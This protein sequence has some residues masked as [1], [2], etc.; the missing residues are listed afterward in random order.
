M[1]YN[2]NVRPG[3][4]TLLM[5]SDGDGLSD[6]EEVS[7][8]TL[9]NDRDTDDDG[10]SD[11]FE[12]KVQTLMDDGQM[13]P[14]PTVSDSS[15]APPPS[16]IWPDQDSDGLTDCEESI[17][18]TWRFVADFDADY[19]P[20]GIEVAAGTNPFENLY[21]EDTDLDSLLDLFEV[22]KHTNVLSDDPIVR[23]RYAY[24]Y[25]LTDHGHPDPILNP[26]LPQ[27]IKL[28]TIQVTNISLMETAGA[29]P[30]DIFKSGQAFNRGDNIIRLY[31]AQVPEDRPDAPPVFRMAEININTLQDTSFDKTLGWNQFELID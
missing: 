18:G 21:T 11:Y 31:I 8:G 25:Q 3:I 24:S 16:G 2:Y 23:S 7:L 19:I 1:A 4:D 5:D 17:K 29:V 13:W 10:L 6:A 22:Q 26:D 28:Y 14:D 27:G 12:V 9:P 20:D 15:C 30:N